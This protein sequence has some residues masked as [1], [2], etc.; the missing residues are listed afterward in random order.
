MYRLFAEKMSWELAAKYTDD[1]AVRN[2][3]AESISKI[4]KK[5]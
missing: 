5:C 3:A 2:A 1:I 4:E